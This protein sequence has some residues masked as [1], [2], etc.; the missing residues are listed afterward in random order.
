M[1]VYK[2]ETLAVS[3][4]GGC[5]SYEKR[6]FVIYDPWNMFTAIHNEQ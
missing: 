6:D 1:Q 3:V 2:K 5:F 4:N